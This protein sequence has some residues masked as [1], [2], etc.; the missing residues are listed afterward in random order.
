MTECVR[1]FRIW[2]LNP[3]TMADWK[4]LIPMWKRAQGKFT[5]S[6]NLLIS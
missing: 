1:L 3:K 6:R 4:K 2:A 5:A